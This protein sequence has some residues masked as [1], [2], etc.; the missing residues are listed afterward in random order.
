MLKEQLGMNGNTART[1]GAW[2]AG[3]VIFVVILYLLWDIQSTLNLVE[4]RLDEI[5]RGLTLPHP[6][7]SQ[8]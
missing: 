2:T 4:K 7:A 6:P 5:H 1:L 8:P 3:G